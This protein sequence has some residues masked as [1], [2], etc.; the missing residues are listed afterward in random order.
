MGAQANAQHLL[1]ESGVSNSV[2]G[3]D[4]DEP[5][6]HI[7]ARCHVKLSER[8]VR[9]DVAWELRQGAQSSSRCGAPPA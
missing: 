7:R 5:T 9:I 3:Q 4:Y 2:G 1:T 6:S 8:H